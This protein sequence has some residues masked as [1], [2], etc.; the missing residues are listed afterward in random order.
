[1]KPFFR[2]SICALMLAMAPGW[3]MPARAFAQEAVA[4]ERQQQLE[5]NRVDAVPVRLDADGRLRGVVRTKEG[6]VAANASVVL[7]VKGKPV[8]RATANA[9]GQFEFGPLKPGEYQVA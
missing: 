7:G 5:E 1:M 2:K 3:G 8:Q 9:Q 4:S 6:A